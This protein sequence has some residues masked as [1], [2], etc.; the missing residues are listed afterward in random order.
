RGHRIYELQ[1]TDGDPLVEANMKP[2]AMLSA[3]RYLATGLESHKA[4]S[5]RVR[6]IGAAGIGP[7]SDIGTGKPL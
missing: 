6:A 2:L 3:N 4:Y 5:F 7:W 1:Y